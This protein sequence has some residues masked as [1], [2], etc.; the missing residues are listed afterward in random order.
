MNNVI[1]MPKKQSLYARYIKE[2]EGLNCIE[3]EYGFCTWAVSPDQQELHIHEMFIVPERR[4]RGLATALIKELESEFKA[5][6][7][8]VLVSFLDQRAKGWEISRDVQIAYG[9]KFFRTLP[10]GRACFVKEINNNG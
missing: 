3:R 7:G 6:G 2:R 10:D 5:R 8:K 1:E 4:R 9:F